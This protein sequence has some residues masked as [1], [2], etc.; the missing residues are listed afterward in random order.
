MEKLKLYFEKVGFEGGS[1]ERIVESFSLRAF[2]KNDYVVEYGKMSRQIGFI[3]SGMFQYYVL[4]DGEERTSYISV[5]NTW[6]AS[7]LSFISE[8]PSQESIR[9]LT[10]GSIYLINKVNLKS[11]SARFQASTPFT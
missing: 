3:K 10:S 6:L 4:K 1:L 11:L 9:A 8:T 7:L 2:E 5:Q